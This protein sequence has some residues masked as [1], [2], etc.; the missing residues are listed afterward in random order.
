M[1]YTGRPASE[2]DV[3]SLNKVALAFKAAKSHFDQCM[4]LNRVDSTVPSIC[5]MIAPAPA[6]PRIRA[7]PEPGR[8]PRAANPAKPNGDAIAKPDQPRKKKRGNRLE[9]LPKQ[10]LKHKGMFHLV[11]PN[12]PDPFGNLS[13]ANPDFV[14]QGRESK[15]DA[16]GRWIK[17]GVNYFGPRQMPL[18]MLQAI[19]DKFLSDKSG[20]FDRRTFEFF[21]LEP[22]YRPLLGD[23][24]GPKGA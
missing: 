3:S 11:N 12:D 8:Q 17:K 15:K 2:L 7:D 9:E 10:D 21:D 18:I 1:F 19:G 6:A 20:W 22:K 16:N 4:A 14:C 23:A 24:S 5:G 13:D